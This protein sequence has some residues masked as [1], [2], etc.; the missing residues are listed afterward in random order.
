M[1]KLLLGVATLALGLS[2][3]N[4]QLPTDGFTYPVVDGY[5][6]VSLWAQMDKIHNKP[7]QITAN[8]RGCLFMCCRT[9]DI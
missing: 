2:A 9:G 5:Q 8:T 4:A 3:V 1:K 6:V 7:S